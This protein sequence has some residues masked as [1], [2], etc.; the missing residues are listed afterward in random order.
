[1]SF[2]RQSQRLLYSGLSVPR[3]RLRVSWQK[4]NEIETTTR[5]ATTEFI[6]FLILSI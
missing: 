1:M 5:R 6:D 2:I 3:L 4:M